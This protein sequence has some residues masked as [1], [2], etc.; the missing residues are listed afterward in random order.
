MKI[1]PKSNQKCWSQTNI[2]LFI[3]NKLL[4][5]LSELLS[6]ENNSSDVSKNTTNYIILGE[7]FHQTKLVYAPGHSYLCVVYFN[8]WKSAAHA[9]RWLQCVFLPFRTLFG[10]QKAE[11]W[12]KNNTKRPQ[13]CFTDRCEPAFRW[14]FFGSF[15]IIFASCFSIL[16]QKLVQNGKNTY[17]DQGTVCAVLVLKWK[18][19]TPVFHCMGQNNAKWSEHGAKM[20][21]HKTDY[22]LILWVTI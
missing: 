4:V 18:Y 21:A 12:W 19:T 8:H 14:S 22:S 6:H 7:L 15:C 9:I 20:L 13:K 3:S 10:L 5:W 11:W 1:W 2:P 17:F 16:H